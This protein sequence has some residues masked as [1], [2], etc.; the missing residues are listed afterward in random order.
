MCICA[1]ARK[2]FPTWMNEAQIYDP[3]ARPI[4]C[5]RFLCNLYYFPSWA[6]Y[7][8]V[9]SHQLPFLF[10]R[11]KEWCWFQ[12]KK[13]KLATSREYN[14]I[15]SS[16]H[17]FAMRGQCSINLFFDVV[18]VVNFAL[19]IKLFWNGLWSFFRTF[20]LTLPLLH[21]YSSIHLRIII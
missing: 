13:K 16:I 5:L 11:N 9:M 8:S 17:G 7:F 2:C 12:Q 3:I 15:S 19:A 18:V 14:F 4:V 1:F 20:S 21:S 10:N 6:F